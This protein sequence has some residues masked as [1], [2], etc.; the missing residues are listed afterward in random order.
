M[1]RI[2]LAIATL[3]VST[4]LASATLATPPLGVASGAPASVVS[5]SPAATPQVEG[6][7][8]LTIDEYA[9][10]RSVES[11]AISPD[12]NW[13][14]YGYGKREADDQ[15]F[16]E[17][18]ADDRVLE[19]ARGSDPEFSVDSRWVA[20]EIALPWEEI[21]SL[22]EEG[23]PVTVQAELL[24]LD[25][26]ERIGPWDDIADFEFAES[27]L[28][29]AIQRRRER[30][31]G[32]GRGGSGRSSGGNDG[33]DA[34][35]RGADLIV[36]YLQAGYEELLGS[37]D[38]Y[39][40]NEAGTHLAYT[41]DAADNNGNGVYLI[42]LRNGARRGLDNARAEYAGLTWDEAGTSLA[43]LRGSVPEGFE[44]RAN[45]LLGFPGI[46]AAAAPEATVANTR[47]AYDGTGDAA[48][49]EGFVISEHGNLAWND[50]A[51]KLF[52]GIKQQMVE[53]EKTDEPIADVNIFHWND[54]R[55]QTV[56]MAQ[57]ERD[58]NFTFTGVLNLSAGGPGTF[59][60][61]TDDRMRT[62]RLTP[63]GRWGVGADERDYV[64]DWE[65]DR[66]D[67]YRVDIATGERT[68]MLEG[69]QRTLGI[70]PDGSHFLYWL[71]GDV[72]DW[73]LDNGAS[74]SLTESAPVD[75]TDQEFDR[76]GEKPPYGVAGWSADGSSVILYHRYDIWAQPL[77]GGEAINL[78]RGVGNDGEIRLRL[79]TFDD[80]ARV[81]FPGGG[82]TTRFD[83]GAPQMLSAF[84]EWTKKA[85]YFELPPGE[86]PRPLVFGDKR[87]GTP[88][89]AAEAG[90]YMYT[91]QDFTQFP[92]YWVA[93][94]TPGS[95]GEATAVS[96]APW[97][98]T[99]GAGGNEPSADAEI[100]AAAG[101]ASP[102]R[103]T[104]ANPF[105]DE[106]K[107]GHRIL[108]EYTNGDGV[109][110]QG[111]LAIP[112][113]Y[114]AGEQ[115]PMIVRFYEQY[116]QD[117]HAYPMPQYRHSP[118]FAGYVSAGYLIMQPDVHFNGRTPHSDMLECVEAATRKVIEM[119]YADPGAVGL[120]GHS[121]SG[122]GSSFIAGT[123]DMF[124]AVASG[125]APINLTS[126][127][128]QLFLGSGQNNHSYDIYGQGR[129]GTNPY[130]DPELYR[131]ESPITYAP[132]MNTPLL[133]LHGEED[134]TVGYVQGL[135]WYNALRFNGKPII[136]LSYPDEGHGL[137]KHEN[138]L[139]FQRRL[140]QFFDH[141]LRDLEAP[142]WMLEGV[143]FLEKER[144][145]QR[146][147]R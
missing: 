84:G 57:A 100:V 114:V 10:F 80:A 145:L 42:D 77:D 124:A 123:S 74:V 39:A 81:A 40:F 142:L 28:A 5:M 25:S 16:V 13:V 83:L 94:Y 49:P 6:K 60:R 89:K 51:D 118:N 67:Y 70:S 130:D 82:F 107:W 121:Y 112:D 27:S 122:G 32:G 11:T 54:E 106:Y 66:A 53:P 65:P 120:S 9:R 117:L 78:T 45:T 134:M 8:V 35:P 119:G 18:L 108:F 37:V 3:T 128:N 95:A 68:P 91:V 58:R 133:Y 55:I 63:D 73:N 85:G 41:V 113:D 144:R 15:M 14:S 31:D 135:E 126:E 2:R 56:Q 131:Q 17:S 90:R 110:L 21:E 136:F 38:E 88:L 129:Y 104:E 59:V 138:Q 141:Y 132:Q 33:A 98:R 86:A 26:G 44:E 143:T 140:R 23:D 71:D 64:S 125:A 43:V 79:V 76:F 96:G 92:D 87:F 69:Q 103:I 111:T 24:D 127:F 146:R 4:L 30:G 99:G 20:Y 46:V 12:G 102:R 61:L 48:F 34:A 137:R 7:R 109:R 97:T 72:W 147:N 105:Q 47:F 52:F 29:L 116:S 1:P 36:R 75:F 93:D 101:F 50:G 22:E 115:R 19:I 139:D 62:I